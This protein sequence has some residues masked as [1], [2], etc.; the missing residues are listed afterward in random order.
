GDSWKYDVVYRHKGVPLHGLVVE[1]GAKHIILKCIVRKPGRPTL[2]FTEYLPRAEIARIVQAE[3]A[4][5]ALLAGRLQ[6]LVRERE[7]LEARL[8]AVGPGIRPEPASSET[9]ALRTVP[10]IG[11]PGQQALAYDSTHFRLLSNEGPA[12]VELAALRLE[13]VYAAYAGILPPR[14]A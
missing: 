1:H 7:M 11:E 12:L 3:P 14:A 10:W 8:K 4:E 13:Q 6:A 2:I 9:L 5:R